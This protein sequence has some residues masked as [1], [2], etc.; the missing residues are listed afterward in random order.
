VDIEVNK[1]KQLMEHH[2]SHGN[3][4]SANISQNIIQVMTL[5]ATSVEI[6]MGIKISG[7]SHQKI[8]MVSVNH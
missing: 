4:K 2:A 5:K 6:Q 3:Y 8:N 7:A 1:I